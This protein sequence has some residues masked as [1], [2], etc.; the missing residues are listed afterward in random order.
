[1]ENVSNDEILFFFLVLDMVPWNWTLVGF[2][3]IWQSNW[4]GKIA[5]KTER[6]Q[7]PFLSDVFEPIVSLDH[8]VPNYSNHMES[9]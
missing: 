3:Y 8:K 6:K 2:S 7:V 1:M 4:V 9:D 5:I